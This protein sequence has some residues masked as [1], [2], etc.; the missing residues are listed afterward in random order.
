AAPLCTLPLTDSL[1]ISRFSSSYVTATASGT[2]INL[3]AKTSGSG[4]N[5][6]LSTSVTYDTNHFSSSSFTATSSGSTLTGGTTGGNVYDSGTVS[7][8]V[9][10]FTAGTSYSQSVNNTSSLIASSLPP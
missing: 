8:A 3:T 9:A 4:T 7:V 6:P 5:Y 10:G 1:P 2:V